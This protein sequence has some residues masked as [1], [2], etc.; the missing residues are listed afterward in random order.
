[1]TVTE[2]YSLTDPDDAEAVKR[3]MLAIMFRHPEEECALKWW[4]EAESALEKGHR[5]R[6]RL[7][8]SI[9]D[10]HDRRV[11]RWREDQMGVPLAVT[12][13]RYPSWVARDLS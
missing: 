3:L 10:W 8:D 13:K 12:K 7:F 1:M 11:Q 9:G 2:S 6:A 4:E 5:L